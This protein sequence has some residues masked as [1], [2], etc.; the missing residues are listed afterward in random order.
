M[1]CIFLF[2]GKAYCGLRIYI[3][4]PEIRA[5]VV[6]TIIIDGSNHIQF[7]NNSDIAIVQKLCTKKILQYCRDYRLRHSSTDAPTN[8]YRMVCNHSYY[9]FV[10]RHFLPAPRQGTRNMNIYFEWI[11]TGAAPP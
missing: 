7:K 5:K 6:E 8:K 11:P 3:S 9:S 2:E 4:S 10:F 1:S